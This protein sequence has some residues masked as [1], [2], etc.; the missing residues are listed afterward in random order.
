MATKGYYLN[1]GKEMGFGFSIQMPQA[2][3]RSEKPMSV[4]A[5]ITSACWL[6]KQSKYFRISGLQYSLKLWGNK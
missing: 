1:S 3:H 4:G 6:L 5:C 2:H